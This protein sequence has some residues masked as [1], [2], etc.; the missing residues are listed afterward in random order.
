MQSV[1]VCR[2]ASLLAAIPLS[3][4]AESALTRSEVQARFLARNP[5]LGSKSVST[6]PA[7]VVGLFRRAASAK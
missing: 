1:R 3:L 7:I 2:V 4:Y 5:N 6:L